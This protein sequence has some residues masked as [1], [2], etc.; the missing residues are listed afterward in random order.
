MTRSTVSTAKTRRLVVLLVE[1]SFAFAARCREA[2]GRAGAI[3]RECPA[4]MA[5]ATAADW[6][7]LALLVT[8]AVY[9]SHTKE[10]DLTAKSVGAT[11]LRLTS[12]EVTQEELDGRL[13]AVVAEFEAPR[14]P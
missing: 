4:A 9:A 3:L 1:G 7:P 6:Q 13:R 10:I 11:L 8:E 2:A 5:A 12:E 14:S